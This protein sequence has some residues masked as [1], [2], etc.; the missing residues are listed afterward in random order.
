VAGIEDGAQILVLAGI[1]V[2]LVEEQGRAGRLGGR[3]AL[4]RGLDSWRCILGRIL[5]D[6]RGQAVNGVERG[7]HR[8]PPTRSAASSPV[9]SDI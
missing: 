4:G 1:G 2:G 3:G 7:D 5:D 9:R 6:G 8:A